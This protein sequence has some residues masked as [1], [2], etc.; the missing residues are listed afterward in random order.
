MS[1]VQLKPLLILALLFAAFVPIGTLTHELG[2]MSVAWMHGYDAQ[3]HYAYAT[4]EES[5]LN[6]ERIRLYDENEE[7]IGKGL[8]FPDKEK[9]LALE[10]E[11]NHENF[12]ISAGGPFQTILTG[13]LG[14]LILYFRKTRH[15][16]T[17]SWPDWLAV[18]LSLFWLREIFNPLVSFSLSS[19]TPGFG[20]SYGGDEL[21]MAL[22]KG[23]HPGT[24][25]I[26]LAII[27]A[28]VA[29][30][31]V[32]WVVPVKYR[33]SFI[34]AGFLG[35]AIGFAGWMMWLGPMLLP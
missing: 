25:A 13:I 1:R 7:A 2:H 4:H 35:A 22:Y 16:T 31:V 23:L 12:L 6:A 32:F 26:P 19:S 29:I 20:P 10:N 8:D 11:L 34:I 14:L 3:L 9:L 21:Y 33:L 28:I 5:P 27:G 17:W 30:Y 24:F 18:F 15:K